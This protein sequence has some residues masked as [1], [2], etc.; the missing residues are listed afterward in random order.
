M[1]LANLD[2]RIVYLLVFLALSIPLVQRYSVRPARMESAEKLYRIVQELDSE[3]KGVAFVALD[4]GPNTKAENQAQAEVVIEHLMRK[5]VPVVLFSLYALAEPFLKLVPERV[6][7]RLMK[8]HPGEK[9]VYGQDWVNLGYRPGASLLIQSIPKSDDLDELFKKD[10]RGN[11]LKDLPATRHFKSLKDIVFLAEFTGLVG[12]F[13]NYVQFFRSKDYVP[14]FGHGCTSITIPE[15]YIY[16]DSGQLNGLLEGI[17]GAA[18]YSE[19]LMRD[20]P[21]REID[22]S[23]LINTGLGVAHL[24]LIALIVFGNVMGFLERKKS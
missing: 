12:V 20:N 5:R 16:M 17:A 24:I 2:R 7:S 19:L 1:N 23:A 21:E 6:A 8:E 11:D 14:K 22:S 18:W 13:Q 9:W 3:K 15:A 10:V 4:F